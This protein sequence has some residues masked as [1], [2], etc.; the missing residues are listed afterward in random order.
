M[1]GAHCSA[2]SR[3]FP[4][5]ASLL[6]LVALLCCITLPNRSSPAFGALAD[7]GQWTPPKDWRSAVSGYELPV[8]FALHQNEPNPFDAVTTIRFDLP[9][10][11]HVR[12]EVFDLLGRRVATLADAAYPAGFHAVPWN[13][14]AADRRA[15]P[16]MYVYRIVA[17]DQRAER[18]MM[19]VP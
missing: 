15:S 19:L 2:P 5:Q 13:H 9:R 3:A 18:K 4:R 10:A 7:S 6:A 1:S 14:R 8:T 12:L 11:A 16:G 17:G